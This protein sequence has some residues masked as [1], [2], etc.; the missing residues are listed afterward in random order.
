MT[1]EEAIFVIKNA[2]VIPIS[3]EAKVMAIK[4]LEQEPCEDTISRQAVLDYIYNDLGL[5]DEE[6]G[7]DVERL[8]ELESSYRY[9]KSLPPVT[10]QS[11]VVEKEK[12]MNMDIDSTDNCIDKLIAY[13]E[14]M[15]FDTDVFDESVKVVA[16][17]A[18]K[19]ISKEVI[20]QEQKWIPV[21]ERL[22][23]K[24]GHYWCTFGGTNL[25]GKD[26]Y[27]TES[28]AKEIF[29]EP[30]EYA[31]WRSQ[32]VIAWMPLPEPYKKEGD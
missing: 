19:N 28:D 29:D 8:M 27:T 23:E 3:K 22:P 10:S 16:L 12:L 32:N 2:N 9:V 4:A 15:S 26:Y 6:N 31:G 1:N 13:C 20:P 30:E 21:S 18:V 17:D 7:K 25:T 11:K 14:M 24:S 5:G